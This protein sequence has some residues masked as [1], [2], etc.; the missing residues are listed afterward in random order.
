MNVPIIDGDLSDWKNPF[1]GPFVKHNSGEKGAQE[2]YVSL[3]WDSQNL[4]LAY[5]CGDSKIVGSTRKHDYPIFDRDDLV[6][7]F[8]DADG[9]S[10]NY[11]EI[12]VNAFSTNYDM[13]INCVSSDCG[14]WKTDISLDI[15]QM[16]T[17]SK[18]DKD[19]FCVE[20]K[21]PFSSLSTIKN[22]GF[23]IPTINTKWRGNIF[24]IDYGKE[25]DY[26]AIS[27]YNGSQFGFHQ[28]E[29]FKTFEF[30]DVFNK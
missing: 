18:I 11:L 14:G 17:V 30:K 23:L 28:P 26:L 25:T 24:R 4:Y 3:S 7:I 27:A 12:G 22:S 20:I 13:L 6:E 10:Q 21:L 15:S 5:R 8:I 2:T 1:I 19:G 9:D 29:Q 16:E